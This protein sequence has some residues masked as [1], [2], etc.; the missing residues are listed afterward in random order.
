MG[1]QGSS[2]TRTAL[3]RMLTHAEKL[4][5]GVSGC[6]YA[7]DVGCGDSASDA[8]D[9]SGIVSKVGRANDIEHEAAILRRFGEVDPEG[10]YHLVMIGN[11]CVVVRNLRG[12]SIADASHPSEVWKRIILRR[13]ARTL[14]QVMRSPFR[15]DFKLRQNIPHIVEA[16]RAMEKAHI[17]YDDLSA[18]NIM[19]DPTDGLWRITD[20]GEAKLCSSEAEARRGRFLLRSSLNTLLTEIS[21]L[22]KLDVQWARDY[23]R[24]TLDD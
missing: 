15:I 7:G 8:R 5:E 16:I 17:K 23:I 21:R 13:G 9:Q 1:N 22:S 4:G 18:Q 20:F 6:V 14:R 12:C 2:S 10:K 3:A 19:L 11:P 24:Q